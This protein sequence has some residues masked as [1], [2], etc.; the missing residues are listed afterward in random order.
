V[1]S[2]L[3]AQVHGRERFTVG[4]WQKSNKTKGTT[5][6]RESELALVID[7]GEVVKTLPQHQASARLEGSLITFHCAA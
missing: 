1:N 2:Y 5:Q 3:L 6:A 7:V 4:E